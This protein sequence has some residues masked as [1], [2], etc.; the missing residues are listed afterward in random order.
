LRRAINH[1]LAHHGLDERERMDVVLACSE[2]ASNVIEHAHGPIAAA[3]E[4]DCHCIDEELQISI[5]DTGAWR[6]SGTPGRGRGLNI[7]RQV[8][9]DVEI[10]RGRDGTTL[11]LV[12][13]LKA[14]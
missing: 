4:V 14:R 13:R 1:W 12:K 2:A 8:M 10:V 3:F 11:T 7:M 6:P 9:D 5:R